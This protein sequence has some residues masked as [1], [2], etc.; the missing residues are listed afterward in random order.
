MVVVSVGQYRTI[1]TVSGDAE[2]PVFPVRLGAGTLESAAVDE[3]AFAVNLKH[4]FGTGNFLSRPKGVQLDI[5]GSIIAR[6]PVFDTAPFK[7][8]HL[9]GSIKTVR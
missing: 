2:V 5:H 3:V 4:M 1:N 7:I 8:L 6:F 9:C